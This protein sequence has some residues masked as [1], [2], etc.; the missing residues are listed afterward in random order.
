MLEIRNV[1]KIYKTKGGISTKALDDVSIS[2]A[3]TGLVFLL[4]KSGSGKSTL[5]N[6]SGGLDSPTQGEVVVKGKSSKD[7]SGADFDSYRNTFVGFV[8]Q[9]Y[10]VLDEF[11]VEDNIALALELQG[12]S[13]DK[14]KIK[15]LLEEV[16]LK[17]YAK[18]K[19]NTLSGGQK[20]RIAI[21]RALIKDPQIIMADEP[22]G[23][24]DSATGKQVLDTLKKL[25]ETR[26]VIVV[27]HDRDFAETYGDRIV[28]LKDGKIIS[29][30]TKRSIAP[31]ALDNNISV[32]GGDT[33]TIKSGMQ[34]TQKNIAAI[35]NFL[36]K[37]SGDVVI[38]RGKKEIAAFR[39]A[40][41]MSEAGDTESF[42]DTVSDDVKIK[43]YCK[44]D[45]KFIRSRLPAGKAIKI[46][47]SGLKL[48]PV[49]L[50]FT[51]FLSFVAFVM[52]GLFSTLM[53][54]DGDTVAA[55]SFAVAGGDYIN[56]DKK[57]H[58]RLVYSDGTVYD[59]EWNNN[60]AKFT[61]D[62]VESFRSKFGDGAFATFGRNSVTI[63][64]ADIKDDKSDEYYVNSISKF[65]QTEEGT[66]RLPLIEGVYPKAKNEI[67][68]SSYLVTVL[69]NSD[70][71]LVNEQG[72]N[73]DLIGNLSDREVAF[74]INGVSN[75]IGK[76]LKLMFNGN[77]TGFKI[78]GVFDSGAIDPKYNDIR[79]D[80]V[81]MNSAS[82]YMLYYQYSQYIAE[83]LHTLAIVSEDFYDNYGSALNSGG[84][85]TYVWEFND[86]YG[87]YLQ[88]YHSDREP[89]TGEYVSAVKVYNPED[90]YYTP[91]FLGAEK[92]A[93]ADDEIVV[94]LGMF[95]AFI[96]ERWSELNP[97]PLWEDYASDEEYWEDYL[98]WSDKA[99]GFSNNLSLY[100]N[101]LNGY[102]QEYDEETGY[103]SERVPT[104]EER[105]EAV[106][107]TTALLKEL[108][109]DGYIPVKIAEG[110]RSGKDFKIVGWFPEAYKVNI[111]R[112]IY[113]SQRFYD[114]LDTVM[115][116][117]ST[118]Q[119]NYVQPEDAMYDGIY[120][121]YNHTSEGFRAILADIGYKHINVATDVL[122]EINS[123]LYDSVNEVNSIADLLSTVFLVVGIVF[124]VFASLLM[125]N[126][127][128]MSISNKRKEIGIL[129]A[130]GARGTDVFKI[131][132]AESGIIV[133]ICLVLSVIGSVVLSIVINNILRSTLGLS[134]TIFV[135]GIVSL[136]MMI[137]LAVV[138]AFISTFL[139]V[140]FAARK[141]PVESIRAL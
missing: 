52:F 84:N 80:N 90:A 112:G 93:L 85:Y 16:D 134:V 118:E 108:A 133:G 32:V 73:V 66:H 103:W 31:E 22:T 1:T 91:E 61:P 33:L 46:G 60:Y 111:N 79:D 13:K 89:G 56:I 30:V 140:Y 23:A 97:E 135:F 63:A 36:M 54:Y 50:V 139:P 55:N 47:A 40:N 114:S 9:E 123:T 44:E 105:A 76:N 20:Q 59:S 99:N 119:T 34:L 39:K 2:F 15:A 77:Y 5:L 141:K 49:R 57:Y 21:A 128:S 45:S 28:E 86:I 48:K 69:E 125:F 19:P 43:E 131:F 106:T 71:F 82:G 4:G 129:R 51:I 87:T 53:T 18:R 110:D 7:F 42:S 107:A 130:V 12:K 132:F 17:D 100:T 92:T 38:T 8:F 116:V 98:Q 27:S 115:Y 26:L 121:P 136:L 11:N 124:A 101:I 117:T 72:K 29:D 14:E 58:Y 67:C 25:S 109:P 65:T 83:C 96:R 24:L 104:K 70:Y 35:N 62:E 88:M 37:S 3:D 6:V 75:V 126:F 94:S 113:V 120:I 81:N 138:I 102:Y 74:E 64:N 127:I 122:Y 95:W 78:V 41:R 10:N 137:A 68:I